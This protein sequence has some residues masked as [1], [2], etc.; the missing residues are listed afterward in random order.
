MKGGVF[1]SSVTAN[2]PCPPV[3][4]K[5]SAGFLIQCSFP[6]GSAGDADVDGY[7]FGKIRF[8][9]PGTYVYTVA[10]DDPGQMVNCSSKAG[11]AVYIDRN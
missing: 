8:T 11:A 6:E 7:T 2:L 9:S 1:C 4:L 10:E 3:I 5:K